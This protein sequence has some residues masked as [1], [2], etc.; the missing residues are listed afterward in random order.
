MLVPAGLLPAAFA[1]VCCPGAPV[2]SEL[3]LALVCVPPDV[4][5]ELE[6]LGWDWPCVFAAACG[7]E[8]GCGAGEWLLIESEEESPSIREAKLSAPVDA[9]GVG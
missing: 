7:A 4:P 1:L 8:A 6:L 2:L 5:D 9:D 3:E